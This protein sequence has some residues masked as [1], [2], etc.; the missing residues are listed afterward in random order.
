MNKHRLQKGRGDNQAIKQDKRKYTRYNMV[1]PINWPTS[2]G[3]TSS[4]ILLLKFYGTRSTKLIG[5]IS[6][7]LYKGKPHFF[8]SKKASHHSRCIYK[9]SA[10]FLPLNKLWNLK[11]LGPNCIQIEDKTLNSTQTCHLITGSHP[12]SLLTVRLCN[13]ARNRAINCIDHEK[14]PRKWHQSIVDHAKP[15]RNVAWST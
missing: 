12:A 10:Y 1:R 8:L 9:S 7:S 14:P 15:R 3:K 4:M 11:K 2:I 6:T 5:D 13:H